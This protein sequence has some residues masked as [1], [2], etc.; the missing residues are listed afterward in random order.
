MILYIDTHD[1]DKIVLALIKNRPASPKRPL[2]LASSEARS[3]GG[4]VVKKKTI[5]ATARHSE[6]LLVNIK[7]IV[8]VEKL[9]GIII[10]KGPGSFSSLRIGIATANTLAFVL[11]IPIYSVM[12]N[13]VSLGFKTQANALD[14]LA[15]NYSKLKKEKLVIP[16]YGRE[17]NITKSKRTGQY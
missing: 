8:L 11:K 4:E 2:R 7:K 16:F 13:H 3:E 17:P 15:K 10:V 5:K 6:K 14:L 12:A 9:K 1:Y